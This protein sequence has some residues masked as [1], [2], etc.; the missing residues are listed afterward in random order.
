MFCKIQVHYHKNPFIHITYYI[1][2]LCLPLSYEYFIEIL[3]SSKFTNYKIYWKTEL[4]IFFLF[5]FQLWNSWI[6]FCYFCN[7]FWSFEY[8]NGWYLF[9]SGAFLARTLE[10]LWVW[11]NFWSFFVEVDYIKYWKYM[12]LQDILGLLE[13]WVNY[14]TWLDEHFANTSNPNNSTIIKSKF[15]KSRN[16]T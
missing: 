13:F 15:Q 12:Q 10:I 14:L 2:F 3:S 1:Y 5:F 7:S 4:Q 11:H 8:Y 6:N 9:K 16:F